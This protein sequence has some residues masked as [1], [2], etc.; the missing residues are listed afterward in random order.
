LFVSEQKVRVQP[1][2]SGSDATKATIKG[3]VVNAAGT[4]I[5]GAAI[6]VTPPGGAAG[7]L[8][9]QVV[10]VV[11]GS[12]GSFSADVK[13]V[14]AS[15]VDIAVTA[16]GYVGATSS[17]VVAIKGR[18]TTAAPIQLAAVSPGVV[19]CDEGFIRDLVTA[20][21]V[22][23]PGGGDDGGPPPITCPD[24]SVLASDGVTCVTAGG[25][26][27]CPVGYALAPDGVSCVALGEKTGEAVK[28]W[29]KS[30]WTYII[31]GGVLLLGGVAVAVA[32]RR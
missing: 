31:G 9:G 23:V 25:G 12:D 10:S 19:P 18:T 20:A 13:P 6:I 14:A 21:C 7:A 32:R 3:K 27:T 26:F 1:R 5:A 11:T 30:K 4:G 24:G 16:A 2:P 22:P 8:L 15:T 29:Y 28:P 17:G